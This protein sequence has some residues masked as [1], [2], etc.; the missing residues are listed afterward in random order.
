[1]MLFD[2]ELI[3]IAI[4]I[5]AS[6]SKFI[7]NLLMLSNH[8]K[9]A[10]RNLLKNKVFSLI[11]IGGLAI[12]MAVAITIGL[13]IY[14]GLSYNTCHK[15]YDRLAQVWVN[16]TFSGKTGSGSAISIPLVG[17]LRT[18]YGNDFDNLAMCVPGILNIF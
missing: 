4:H 1:M 7:T 15:N 14:D 8:L 11:N 17:A 16:Q 10:W 9:I 3:L 6:N 12:G 13:W 2:V 18:Q 5:S